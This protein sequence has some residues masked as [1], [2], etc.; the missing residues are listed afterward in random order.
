MIGA[1]LFTLYMLHIY[2]QSLMGLGN[3][4]WPLLSGAGEF[5]G[6]VGTG[7]VLTKILGFQALY[8]AETAAFIM[9]DLFLVI[10]YYRVFGA[11]LR[12]YEA[13]ILQKSIASS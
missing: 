9:A 11:A 6:R 1:G 12:N 4:F 10:P 8:G 2:R 3:T 13:H 5:I 7:L